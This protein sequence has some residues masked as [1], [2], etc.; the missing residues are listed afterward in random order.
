[1]TCKEQTREAIQVI[2]RSGMDWHALAR[3][4]DKCGSFSAL[5]DKVDDLFPRGCGLG[6]F[7]LSPR[8]KTATGGPVQG[9][10]IALCVKLPVVG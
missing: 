2:N 10:Y 6:P 7:A 4:G 8:T 9:I 3:M 5:Q 1:M